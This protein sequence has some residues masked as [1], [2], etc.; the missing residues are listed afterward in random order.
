MIKSRGE[1]RSPG[2]FHVPCSVTV[3]VESNTVV[4]S[5]TTN[6]GCIPKG[7][8]LLLAERMCGVP[9]L[10]RLPSDPTSS[11]CHPS[12]AQPSI[13]HHDTARDDS[14][15]HQLATRA[16][17]VKG[18]GSG[19]LSHHA[20]AQFRRKSLGSSEICSLFPP[21]PHTKSVPE[22]PQDKNMV[23]WKQEMGHWAQL[24]KW[25]LG[26]KQAPSNDT[27]QPWAF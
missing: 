7:R 14:D 27:L 5:L 12:I 23:T 2:L 4:D 3:G 17:S 22:T 6:M 20:H 1:L 25:D 26:S 16:G 13:R 9:T 21:F 10:A 11:S 18:S 24:G 15:T 8:E 19:H